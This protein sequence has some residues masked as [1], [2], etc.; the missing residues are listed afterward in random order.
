MGHVSMLSDP[1]K[2]RSVSSLVTTATQLTQVPFFVHIF[3]SRT[4]ETTA[5]TPRRRFKKKTMKCIASFLAVIVLLMAG[6]CAA[7][8]ATEDQFLRGLARP[9]ASCGGNKCARSEQCC[10]NT[11]C[12]PKG[13]NCAAVTCLIDVGGGATTATPAGGSPCG[14][15]TCQEGQV[16]CNESCG[17]C[18]PPDGAC[19]MQYCSP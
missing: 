4:L 13:A 7:D 15:S 17:I 16:C 9:T 10:Y 3:Q 1:V 6:V 8:A 18:T 12:A 2:G 5:A 14:P 11:C 19:T